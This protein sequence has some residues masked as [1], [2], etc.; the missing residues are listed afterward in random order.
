MHHF[1]DKMLSA[2][3]YYGI[4][5]PISVLPFFVLRILSN[6]FYYLLYEFV[7]YRKKIV[8]D[9]LNKSFPNKTD[10]ERIQICKSFYKFLSD[11]F[12]ESVKIFTISKK[13]LRQH[14]YCKNPEI[15]A[16]YYSQNKH[17]IIAIAHYN[18]WELFLSG[19]NMLIK[20]QAVIIYQP[21]SDKLINKKMIKAREAF[22]TKMI[23]TKEVKN[24]FKNLPNSPQAI[25]FAIDQ[26]PGNSKNCYWMNFL[27]QETGV[28]YGAEKYAKEFDIPVVFARINKEKRS[29]YNIEFFSVTESSSQTKYGYITEKITKQ[30]E[31]DILEKPEFWLWS[32]RRWKHKKTT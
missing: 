23:A 32:H 4:L 18:S 16:N 31:T 12:L 30:L 26:S 3:L 2:L 9:N 1:N 25:V 7:G 13:T 11:M 28:V 15:L 19:L 5:I 22:G 17:V 27:N 24:Y 8:I 29:H 14:I 6:L 20:H 10:K 21:L